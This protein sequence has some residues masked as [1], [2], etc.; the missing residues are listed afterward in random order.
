MKRTQKC[1]QC[2]GMLK[3]RK[4]GYRFLTGGFWPHCRSSVDS[5]AFPEALGYCRRQC[6]V[7]QAWLAPWASPDPVS[8]SS[9]DWACGPLSGT[10]AAM[11]RAG[12]AAP[13]CDPNLHS[14]PGSHLQSQQRAA[15]K[16]FSLPGWPHLLQTCLGI[17]GYFRVI[18]SWV[19]P[20]PSQRCCWNSSFPGPRDPVL[21]LPGFCSYCAQWPDFD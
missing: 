6:L 5:G 19:N 10:W 9:C 16:P 14:P 15:P 3:V 13:G 17:S 12:V 7:T 11:Q 1:L 4:E 18:Q 20:N 2:T 21:T 8:E